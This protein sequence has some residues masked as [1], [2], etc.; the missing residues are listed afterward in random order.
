MQDFSDP[1]MLT[2]VSDFAAGIDFAT[3]QILN[4]TSWMYDICPSNGISSIFYGN[5]LIHTSSHYHLAI[6]VVQNCLQI[7]VNQIFFAILNYHYGF[8]KVN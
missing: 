2:K 4:L 3:Q 5:N 1:E 8:S 7:S 6:M